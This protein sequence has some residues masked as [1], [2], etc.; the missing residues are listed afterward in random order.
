M[1]PLEYNFEIN[2]WLSCAWEFRQH[3]LFLIPGNSPMGLRLP[4]KSLPEMVTAQRQKEVERSPFETLE[5]L[6][7]Y[8][9]EFKDDVI[10]AKNLDKIPEEWL[11]PKELQ[12][13]EE[14]EKEDEFFVVKKKSIHWSLSYTTM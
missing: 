12:E 6:P 8:H 10:Q 2:S 11:F 13:N 5:N 9:P 3:Q 4:L 1:L 14:E 7:N